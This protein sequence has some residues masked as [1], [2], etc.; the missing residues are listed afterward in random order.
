MR[1][2]GIDLKGNEAI[3]VLVEVDASGNVEWVPRH[4]KKISLG[5]DRDAKELLN[6]RDAVQAYL[7]EH[8]VELIVIK[9]RQ[10]S[11]AMA[12]GPITFKMETVIQL[13]EGFECTRTLRNTSKRTLQFHQHI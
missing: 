10:R 13:I 4:T 9:D 5:D 1:T 8:K 7:Q 12:A 11:G 2:C 3:V 6:F